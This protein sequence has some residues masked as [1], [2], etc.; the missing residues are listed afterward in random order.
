MRLVTR[1]LVTLKLVALA[2]LPNPVGDFGDFG[3]G[4]KKAPANRG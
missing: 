2:T 3:D 4:K 1:F